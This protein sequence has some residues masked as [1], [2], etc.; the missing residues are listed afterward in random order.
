MGQRS[1]AR[2]Y[3]ETSVAEHPRTRSIL[4]RFPRADVVAC[5]RFGEILNR[6]GQS[7]RLQKLRP[8]LILAGK[9][10]RRVLPAPPA[11]GV[12]GDVNFYF[13]H[14]LNC[15]YDCRYCFLQGMFRS[16][17]YVVFVNY[18]DFFSE[19]QEA[20]AEV[21]EGSG[22]A[23]FFS[24][25]D[26]DSLAFDAVTGFA[27]EALAFFRDRPEA[28]LELRTKS[29]RIEALLETEVVPNVVVAFSMSPDPVHQALEQGVPN[30]EAR[31]RAMAA[32]AR[33]GWQLGL[34]FDPVL[35]SETF[36]A[37]Y[38]ELFERVFSAVP[39]PALHSVGYGPFRLPAAF[40]RRMRAQAPGS[41]LLAAT[42]VESGGM[43]GYPA[44]REAELL[45]FVADELGRRVPEEKLFPCVEFDRSP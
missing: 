7:F 45:T 15:L 16:A 27:P 24:G 38:R 4:E 20:L 26:C 28:W 1:I 6:R 8:A 21:A 37:D 44:E 17:H 29:T 12:G 2:I 30:L 35:W 23:W 22:P 32:L 19:I 14:M 18:E 5:D 43:A 11:Y 25:Y 9:Q 13:S 36:R 3:V 33:Q 10:G 42:G 41:A 31:L 40:H 39:A 34:R